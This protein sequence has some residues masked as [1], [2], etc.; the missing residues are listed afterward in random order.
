MN[1][2]MLSCTD[3]SIYMQSFSPLLQFHWW[4]LQ[5]LEL[6][7]RTLFLWAGSGHLKLKTQCSG[8]G[9]AR[10]LFVCLFWFRFLVRWSSRDIVHLCFHSPLVETRAGKR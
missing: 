6:C 7:H 3:Q 1:L 4:L 10:N 8:E 5:G 2:L 9:I